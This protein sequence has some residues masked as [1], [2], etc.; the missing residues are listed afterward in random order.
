MIDIAHLRSDSG[1]LDMCADSATRR[2][3]RI[4]QPD[5]ADSYTRP[6]MLHPVPHR[7]P[8]A[9]TMDSRP[10]SDLVAHLPDHPW[11]AET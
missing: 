8:D 6:E 11:S 4:H 1:D 10:L 2:A 5:R 7:P 3:A 9:V